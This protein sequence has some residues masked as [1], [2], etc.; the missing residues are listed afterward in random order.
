MSAIMSTRRRQ[1]FSITPMTRSISASSGE[2]RLG[3]RADAARQRQPALQE[4][5]LQQ[6]I[7]LL[8]P[9]DLAVDGGAFI[10]H[11][12]AGPAGGVLAAHR[13]L[14]APLV[15]AQIAVVETVHHEA[16]ISEF[17]RRLLAALLLS[18][19]GIWCGTRRD[20][21][22]R[23][24]RQRRTASKDGDDAKTAVHGCS[25]CRVPVSRNLSRNLQ[26]FEHVPAAALRR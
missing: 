6:R 17:R 9:R 10:R 25:P 21:L 23:R 13:H 22:L 24:R 14:A 26:S 1:I 5:A 2:A 19:R 12:A 7:L 15:E 4:R 3:V 11:Q 16:R 8:Q 18:C 20:L